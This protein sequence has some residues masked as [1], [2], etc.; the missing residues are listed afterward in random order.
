[1][2]CDVLYIQPSDAFKE[3]QSTHPRGVRHRLPELP[4]RHTIIS[5]HAPTWGATCRRCRCPR[6]S[7][8]FNPRTHVGC[9]FKPLQ[10]G[11]VDVVISIHAPTWGATQ[12][13]GGHHLRGEISIHAPTWGA[14]QTKQQRNKLCYFN[15][16]T[17][18]GCDLLSF[19]LLLEY[20]ISIHAPTW[21]ATSEPIMAMIP[22]RY[23]NPRTHVGCD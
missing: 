12:R 21:G 5:I 9:D 17:H 3:F 11:A 1:M 14:T 10:I 4:N 15:P 8:N 7:R 16:R 23:F 18:V 6:S 13:P 19:E 20:P 22:T 2:G